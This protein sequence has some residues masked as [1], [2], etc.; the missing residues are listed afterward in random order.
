[1]K[2]ALVAYSL[3]RINMNNEEIK[4]LQEK[5]HRP[6]GSLSSFLAELTQPPVFPRKAVGFT[7]WGVAYR[8]MF[9]V[10][11]LTTTTDTKEGAVV[12]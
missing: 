10:G 9:G 5:H 4:E 7:S 1:M 12:W 6:R 11:I 2:R 8:E 3:G